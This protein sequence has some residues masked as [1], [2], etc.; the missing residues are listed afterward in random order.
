MTRRWSEAPIRVRVTAWYAGALALLPVA[1][2]YRSGVHL[3]AGE[4][5]A[6]EALVQEAD[7]I[8]VATGTHGRCG[9]ERLGFERDEDDLMDYLDRHR[10]GGWFYLAMP[11]LSWQTV[12]V[13]D[14]LCMVGGMMRINFWLFT[15]LVASG[16][17]VR[18][19]VTAWITLQATG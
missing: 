17:L 7:A 6:A 19:A 2:V 14:P 10:A 8:A 18:Y 4:L 11:Y 1:L 12:I 13:G 16:K 15:T 3:F 9:V 5:V